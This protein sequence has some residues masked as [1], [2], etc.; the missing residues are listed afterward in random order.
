MFE[1]AD[2]QWVGSVSLGYAADGKRK[3]K[4]VYGATKGEVLAKLDA[5][6]ASARVG[7][8]P[9]VGSLTV[10]Q[11]LSRWVESSKPGSATRTHEERERLV[12]THLLPRLGGVKLSA[13]N[14]L[15][16]EGFYADMRRDGVGGW[17]VRHSADA[18][19][20]ALNHAVRLK[21]ISSNPAAA[22]GKPRPPAREML[23]LTDG[24]AKRVMATAVGKPIAPLIVIALGSGCRQGELLALTWDDIDTRAG[25]LTVR[26]A[27]S[28]TK[29]GF[30]VKVPKTP[31]SRRTIRLPAFAV[32]ALAAHKVAM[33]KAG[34]IAGPVFCTRTGGHLDK[35]NVLRAFRAVVKRV[36]NVEGEKPVPPKLRFHDLRHTHASILLSKGHSLRAVSQRLGH[37]NPNMTL[38]VY[39]HVLPT[40]DE[41]LAAGLERMIG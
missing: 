15:H 29:A 33:M 1:R 40:D 37:A 32:Q 41:Q 19:G 13:L 3:R 9:H 7:N 14:S 23:F 26:K 18:L 8:L 20:V 28:R 38:R 31:Q 4:T 11:L 25:T 17:A 36:P 27:L 12:N 34:R 22:V 35:K 2:G 6:R 30:V 21:L 24:Q 39:A 16:V 5:L 10:G